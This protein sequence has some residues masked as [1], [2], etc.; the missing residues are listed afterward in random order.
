MQAS[1]NRFAVPSV[2]LLAASTLLAKNVYR[3]L[4]KRDVDD[5]HMMRASRAMMMVV[6]VAALV[7]WQACRGD[8]PRS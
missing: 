1:V 4:L 3:P 2:L 7:L 5:A 8:W 6:A